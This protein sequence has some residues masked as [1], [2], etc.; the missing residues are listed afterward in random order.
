MQRKKRNTLLSRIL[1]MMLIVAM[2]LFT[3]GCKKDEKES[4]KEQD[5][6]VTAPATEDAANEIGGYFLLI[7]TMASYDAIMASLGIG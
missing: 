5:A 6:K 4:P 1:C 3:V 7:P 2:A